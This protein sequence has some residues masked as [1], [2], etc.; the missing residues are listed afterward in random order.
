MLEM[1]A[2]SKDPITTQAVLNVTHKN[3][4]TVLI[5]IDSRASDHYFINKA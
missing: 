1:Q 5:L 2:N 4:S 3:E